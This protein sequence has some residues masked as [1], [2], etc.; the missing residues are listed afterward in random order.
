MLSG[1]SRGGSAEHESGG[2]N[3]LGLGQL[4]YLS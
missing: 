3:N 1:E 4:L 2:K